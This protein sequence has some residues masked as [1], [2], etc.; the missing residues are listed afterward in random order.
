MIRESGF[1]PFHMSL[2]LSDD[3][4]RKL[5]NGSLFPQAELVLLDSSLLRIAFCTG[6]SFSG[7]VAGGRALN[8]RLWPLGSSLCPLWSI[9]ASGVQQMKAEI[10][11][12]CHYRWET[13]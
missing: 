4:V 2:P 5:G 8:C 6:L 10:L 7:C 12:Y 3:F 1:F 13:A 11:V 9:L